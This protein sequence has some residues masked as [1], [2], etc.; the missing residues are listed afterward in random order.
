[1]ARPTPATST[2]AI[3]DPTSLSIV[4]HLADRGPATLEELAHAAG[5]HVNTVRP[6][7]AALEEAEVLERATE[8]SGRRGRPR[9]RYRLAE[10]WA[11]APD[12]FRGAAEL[13]GAALA[14]DAPRKPKLR[15]IGRAWG[16]SNARPSAARRWRP[17]LARTLE[18][19]GFDPAVE[20][21]TV[22]LEG[23]PCPLVLP[24]QPELLCELTRGAVDGALRAEGTDLHVG[25]AE[26]DPA[27]R[28]C[29]LHL[30]R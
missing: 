25:R 20:A 28:R 23:C 8:S 14:T 12:G 29:T 1:M 2:E 11:L 13:F 27:R 19:I 3:A 30:S 4:R 7:V 18:R 26:H 9:I 10:G 16:R 15:G 6:R 21:S 22:R 5:V 17:N 24:D